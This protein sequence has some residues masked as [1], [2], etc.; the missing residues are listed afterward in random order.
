M[1]IIQEFLVPGTQ[2]AAVRF[3][4]KEL[5]IETCSVPDPCEWDVLSSVPV[6][7]FLKD[8]SVRMSEMMFC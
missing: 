4:P 8:G 6:E 5:F 3:H 7:Q 1:L 2:F